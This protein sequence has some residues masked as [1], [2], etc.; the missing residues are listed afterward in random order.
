MAR[1]KVPE[2]EKMPAAQRAEM[3]RRNGMRGGRPPGTPNVLPYGAVKALG[4]AKYRVRKDIDIA[5]RQD[6]SDVAGY[7]LER[8][9]QVLG[10][11][12]NHRKGPTILKAAI[13]VREEMCE[14]IVKEVKV[15]GAISLEE[16]VTKAAQLAAS[17]K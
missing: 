8:M 5:Q 15:G 2:H 16:M 14:P 11:S 1:S 6:A 9:V 3:L 12:I 7:A 10:G 4:T 13:A 17:K